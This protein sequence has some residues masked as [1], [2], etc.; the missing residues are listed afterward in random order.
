MSSPPRPI[1]TKKEDATIEKSTDCDAFHTYP[2][3]V[4]PWNEWGQWPS[5]GVI[6]W[7]YFRKKYFRERLIGSVLLVLAAPAIVVLWCMVRLH[8]KGDGFFRQTRVGFRGKH[9]EILKLR[10]MVVDAEA[11]GKARWCV[12]GDP[13]IT[14]LGRILRKT[15][16][17]ELPQLIN[18]ARG[19]MALVGP[20]PERP[21]FVEHLKKEIDGYEKRLSVLPGIT[22]LAQVNLPPDETIDDVRRKQYLDLLYIQETNGGLDLR[23][24][25]GTSVRMVGIPGEMVARWLGLRR[26][27]PESLR[28]T[29][30]SERNSEKL[31]E[32]LILDN[33]VGCMA[34]SV[35]R[36]AKPRSP[37]PPND[38]TLPS[39]VPNAFTVDVED[40]FH[41]SGFADRISPRA[42]DT[43]PCRVETNTYRLLELL[44]QKHVRG[45]FFIL[46][47]VADRYPQLVRRIVD[48]GHELG[49]HSYWHRLIYQMTPQEFEED[50]IHA[51]HAIEQAAGVQVHLFRAPSFSITQASLWAIDILNEH[52]FTLDSSIFPMKRDRYGIPE[53]AAAIH[54]HA[55][56]KLAI[57]E[58][59]P[60]V[61]KAGPIRVPV[62]GGYFRL[63]PRQ[64]TQMAIN[65]ARANGIPAMF[66]MHPW[67]IDPQQPRVDGVRALNR[68]R[69]RVGLS[70]AYSK[71]QWILDRN[72]FAAI[73]DVLKHF[74]LGTLPS[75]DPASSEEIDELTMSSSH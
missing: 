24:L 50:L 19:E 67:E 54:Q 21:C 2:Y 18:V 47:W 63:A 45:T 27:I 33:Q 74:D 31:S 42:W 44:Q 61:W 66:Y 5:R 6:R 60:T 39:Y 7:K 11:D 35:V 40:Y 3:P 22:G 14:S 25:L 32:P 8:S 69:H 13:R 43:F 38:P 58:Y 62:G 36:L 49:C 30:L 37:Q 65:G 68:F 70:T 16:L 57:H 12:K 23:M 72:R 53:S 48:A 29:D 46:G 64:V 75:S 51:Q 73:S 41:V 4:D 15:H 26:A 59:P 17:D 52:G 56:Y 1:P 9:F 10:T 20:R 34:A 55:G 71:L 28:T